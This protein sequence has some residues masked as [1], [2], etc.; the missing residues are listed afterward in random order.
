MWH[1]ISYLNDGIYLY[2]NIPLKTELL[3]FNTKNRIIFISPRK[4]NYYHL[5]WYFTFI[6]SLFVFVWQPVH[7]TVYRL[8]PV[9]I[10]PSSRFTIM[11]LNLFPVSPSLYSGRKLG[12]IFGQIVHSSLGQMAL[13]TMNYLLNT[14][15]RIII[16]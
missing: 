3:S 6:F 15:N 7:I 5:I 13:S 1:I 8:G 2:N 12:F 11:T 4:Q 14:E 9:H 16:I 10:T